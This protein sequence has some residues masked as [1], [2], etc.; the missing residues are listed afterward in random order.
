VTWPDGD[1]VNQEEPACGAH[2]Q[3]YGPV[4]LGYVT[5]MIGDLALDCLLNPPS[6]SLNRVF[7]TSPHRIDDLGG[8]W[9][10]EWLAEQGDG[11]PGVRTVDR[12]WPRMACA[13]CQ[14]E[15]VAG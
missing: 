8:R 7:A 5:A 9:S 14:T 13:A 3:P 11:G 10:N 2:Y 4:E 15:L 12:P 1:D 6:Q